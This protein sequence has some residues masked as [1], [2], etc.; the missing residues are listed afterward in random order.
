M[1]ETVC[2]RDSEG[3]RLLHPTGLALSAIRRNSIGALWAWQFT[4]PM[5][6]RKQIT[7]AV[8]VAAFMSLPLV[9]ALRRRQLVEHALEVERARLLAPW[10]LGQGLDEVA[11][12]SLRRHPQE[13]AIAAPAAVTHALIVGALERISLEVEQ[14]GHAERHHRI[15]PDVE[16][17]A[18]LLHEGELPLVVAKTRQPAVVG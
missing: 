10:K 13:H 2:T 12:E 3:S 7:D 16:A 4:I 6:A 1:S 5:P 9:R 8:I 15:L 11:H 18:A 17:V 14:L